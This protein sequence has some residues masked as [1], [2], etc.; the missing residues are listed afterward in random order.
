MFIKLLQCKPVPTFSG[1]NY[2]YKLR[3]VFYKAFPQKLI[4]TSLN[5]PHGF[6]VSHNED[7]PSVFSL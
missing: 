5:A 7:T 6:T 4:L 3:T 2:F 1:L